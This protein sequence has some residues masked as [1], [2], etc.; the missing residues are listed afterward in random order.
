MKEENQPFDDNLVCPLMGNLPSLE[1]IQKS[2]GMD[3]RVSDKVLDEAI[4]ASDFGKATTPWLEHVLAIN[5]PAPA[6]PLLRKGVLRLLR[7]RWVEQSTSAPSNVM[8]ALSTQYTWGSF[9]KSGKEPMRVRKLCNLDTDHIE[10]ILFYCVAP[11]EFRTVF[12][13]ILRRRAQQKALEACS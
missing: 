7:K 10:N 11:V 9:G 3:G 13:Y 1:E 4:D 6:T 8:D 2:T 12:V 5:H